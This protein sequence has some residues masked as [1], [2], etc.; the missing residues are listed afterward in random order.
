M[1]WTFNNSKKLI[2]DNKIR[3]IKLSTK[4]ES[5]SRAF[6]AEF[7]WTRADPRILTLLMDKYALIE[8][9]MGKY[10]GYKKK[11]SSNISGLQKDVPSDPKH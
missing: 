1:N 9:C 4:N 11:L 6:M 3:E 8:M 5:S 2:S 10:K 7:L